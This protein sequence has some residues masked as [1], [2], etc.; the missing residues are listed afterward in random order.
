MSDRR[1]FLE[2]LLAGTAVPEMTPFTEA[3]SVHFTEY[4][5]VVLRYPKQIHHNAYKYIKEGWSKL[6]PGVKCVILES[7]MDIEILK[8]GK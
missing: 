2:S 1:E 8:G 4:D 3:K 5:T 7:G 6:F